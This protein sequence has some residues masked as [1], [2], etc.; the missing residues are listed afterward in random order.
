[1]RRLEGVCPRIGSKTDS[2]PPTEGQILKVKAERQKRQTGLLPPDLG[3]GYPRIG[4][5]RPKQGLD[6]N[7]VERSS[8][9]S[10]HRRLGHFP[11]GNS[12]G[13]KSSRLGFS[14]LRHLE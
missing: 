11:Y 13:M 2:R 5:G 9:V 14:K 12:C 7:P 3:R 1:M 10:H 4:F 6:W 8:S